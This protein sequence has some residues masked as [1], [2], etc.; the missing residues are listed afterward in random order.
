MAARRHYLLALQK[1]W[2]MARVRLKLFLIFLGPLGNYARR[3]VRT[4]RGM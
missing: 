4:F 2:R 1:D 3:F